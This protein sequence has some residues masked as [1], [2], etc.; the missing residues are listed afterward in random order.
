MT[1]VGAVVADKAYT[2]CTLSERTA[3]SF[4]RISNEPDRGKVVMYVT[5][6]AGYPAVYMPAVTKKMYGG[7]VLPGEAEVVLPRNTPMLIRGARE[8][9]GIW[10]VD[11]EVIPVD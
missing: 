1:E 9:N 3:N 6:P 10:Y 5:V 11:A 8:E 7:N 2:S 4:T